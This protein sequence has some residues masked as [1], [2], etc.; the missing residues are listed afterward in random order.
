MTGSVIRC[1]SPQFDPIFGSTRFN[2]GA[3]DGICA[4]SPNSNRRSVRSPSKELP[5][6]A[7]KCVP[8]AFKAKVRREQRRGIR[9]RKDAVGQAPGFTRNEAHLSFDL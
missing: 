8:A 9:D 2:V 4:A 5:V 1:R 6:E 3:Q 7:L